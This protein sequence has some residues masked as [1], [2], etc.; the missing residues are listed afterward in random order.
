MFPDVI[1]NVS[2]FMVRR[3]LVNIRAEQFFHSTADLWIPLCPKRNHLYLSS[4]FLLISDFHQKYALFFRWTEWYWI[5]VWMRQHKLILN[6]SHTPGVLFSN[7]KATD[8]LVSENNRLVS[9]D[10]KEGAELLYLTWWSA[11]H[12]I[13]LQF[14]ALMFSKI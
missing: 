4:L 11:G 10:I 1:L 14:Y 7:H 3:P 2:A 13:S 5:Y 9:N 12:A 6:L 8:M